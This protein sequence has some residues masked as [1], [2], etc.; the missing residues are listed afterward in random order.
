MSRIH[1]FSGEDTTYY[2][3]DCKSLA[4]DKVVVR[5]PVTKTDDII[6][7]CTKCG[8]TKIESVDTFEKYMQMCDKENIEYI[9]KNKKTYNF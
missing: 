5:N 9:K 4:I 3:S 7:K 6:W 1:V 2:C 8:C